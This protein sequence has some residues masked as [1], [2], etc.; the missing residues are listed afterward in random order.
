MSD[1]SERR[2]GY[3]EAKA[4]ALKL[5]ASRARTRSHLETR[6]ENKGFGAE[7]VEE[8][9]DDLERA[10]YVDDGQY[11]RDRIEELLGQSRK[12]PQALVHALIQDGVAAE[13]A[14]R[15]VAERLEGEDLGEWA[16]EVASERA[17]RMRD[18]EQDTARRRLYGYLRRR[19]FG[20]AEAL[21]AID[22]ALE[23]HQQQS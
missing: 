5:L 17:E 1:G 12:G 9:L 2:A 10:G 22:E 8:A 11:A 13:A 4:A 6:L 7:D 20:D 21:R 14:E 18:V 23:E 19:G 16:R 3:R 15:A